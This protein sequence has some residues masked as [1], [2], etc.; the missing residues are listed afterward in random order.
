[1]AGMKCRKNSTKTRLCE[2]NNLLRV[3]DHGLQTFER[4][5]RDVRCEGVK[6]L[7]C[8]LVIITTALKLHSYPMGNSL[9]TLRPNLLIQLR[10][11]S[12]ITRA[13]RLLREVNDRF[14]CPWGPLFEGSAMHAFVQVD[15]VFAGDDVLE[16]GAGLA[17]PTGLL[18]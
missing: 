12:H 3:Q 5:H 8:A 11:Q 2:C 18:L 9:D 17:L 10:V 13:H 6:F 14:D 16:G 4:C 7:F 1:M 15:S